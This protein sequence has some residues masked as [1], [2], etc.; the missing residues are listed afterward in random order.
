MCNPSRQKD[1]FVPCLG[2]NTEFSFLMTGLTRACYLN[3][4]IGKVIQEGT[5]KRVNKT[6]CLALL[7]V[8]CSVVQVVNLYVSDLAHI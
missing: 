4:Y 1:L 8:S 6:P 5:I 3:T 7:P 2:E